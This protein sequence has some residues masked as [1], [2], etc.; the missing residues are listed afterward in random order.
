MSN[1]SK[2]DKIAFNRSEVMLEFEKRLIQAANSLNKK[3]EKFSNLDEKEKKLDTVLQKLDAVNKGMESLDNA[4][5]DSDL[6]NKLDG[7][8][9]EDKSIEAGAQSGLAT[10]ED[11]EFAKNIELSDEMENLEA[12]D[13]LIDEM[14]ALAQKAIIEGNYKVAY[15]IERTISE[16]IDGE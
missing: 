14:E 8:I 6:E 4:A 13:S 16:I 11:I 12:K 5:Y 9:I 7:N 2:E 1:W 10:E 3:L 15:Q